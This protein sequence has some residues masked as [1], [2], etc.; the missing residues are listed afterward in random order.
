MSMILFYLLRSL[1]YN[2]NLIRFNL[3]ST[4]QK[5]DCAISGFIIHSCRIDSDVIETTIKHRSDDVTA[6]A[7]TI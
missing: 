4:N 2:I 5:F 6:L 3:D 1:K 7:K